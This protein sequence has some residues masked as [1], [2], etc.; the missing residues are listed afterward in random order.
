[1]HHTLNPRTHGVLDYLGVLFF[2]VAPSL[3]GF[4]DKVANLSYIIGVAYLGMV[5]LTAY[6]LGLLKWIPFPIHGGVELALGAFLIASPWLLRFSQA[7]TER[8]VMVVTGIALLGVWFLT[9]YRAAD[10][11]RVAHHA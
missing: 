9:D 5:L 11:Q 4:D 8:N 10:H 1:M 6:P 3:F 2:F 7:P